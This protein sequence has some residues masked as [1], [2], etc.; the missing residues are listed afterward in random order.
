VSEATPPVKTAGPAL[1]KLKLVSLALLVVLCVGDLWSKDYMATELGLVPG[2]SRGA[3]DIDVIPGFLAWQG[4]WNPG[5]TFGLA[6]HKTNLILT[7]TGIA[8]LGLLIWFF[9]TR[10]RSRC[11]NV[12]LAMILA[13]ALGN[14]Y[15]RWNWGQVRDFILV[16]IGDLKAPS[17]TWPNFNVADAGI[18]VGVILVL[19]DALFG[20]SAK[21]A[22]AKARAAAESAEAA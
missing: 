19:W 18:V 6:P 2:K 3:H 20:Y 21:L 7:L 16:Y 12:G 14:L 9:G 15:D 4:T 22:R 11:L 13:G 1:G 17:W 10:S 5:V 8:T